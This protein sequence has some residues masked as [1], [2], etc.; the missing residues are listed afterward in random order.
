MKD[1]EKY[2]ADK[3]LVGMSSG[4]LNIYIYKFYWIIIALLV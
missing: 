2:W 4:V 3:T 1:T